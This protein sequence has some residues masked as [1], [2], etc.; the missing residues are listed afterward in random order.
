MDCG[1]TTTDDR[2]V[3]V[4][5]KSP[6]LLMLVLHLGR[7]NSRSQAGCKIS[8]EA[9]FPP[10]NPREHDLLFYWEGDYDNFVRRNDSTAW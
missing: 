5:S 7:Y 3:W 6:T 10:V 1:L 2:G 8:K 4:E 9:F